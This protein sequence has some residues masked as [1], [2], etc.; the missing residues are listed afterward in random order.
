[1]VRIIV[2][3]R[4]EEMD[5]NICYKSMNDLFM[6]IIN[7]IIIVGIEF[8]KWII[9]WKFFFVRCEVDRVEEWVIKDY[10]GKFVIVI[11]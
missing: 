1:M 3:R 5:F 8:R 6:V 9:L 7:R 2:L 10:L 4:K 11:F